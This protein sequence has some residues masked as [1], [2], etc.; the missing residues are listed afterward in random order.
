MSELFSSISDTDGI[1]QGDV[2]RKI[3]P[4][5]DDAVTWGVIVTADCDIAQ[6]KAG[7]RYTWLEIV[8]M[9]SYLEDSWAEDQLRR[10]IE[11]QGKATTE[12]LN[13]QIKRLGMNLSALEPLSLCDWLSSSSA[14]EVMKAVTQKS[15]VTDTKTRDALK[16][17]RVALGF[18]TMDPPLVRLM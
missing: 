7:E 6:K 10:L 11:K 5:P 8:S 2:I 14:D 15:E 13:G 9:K 12:A 3:G 17:I 1:R 18:E 4:Y 16:A